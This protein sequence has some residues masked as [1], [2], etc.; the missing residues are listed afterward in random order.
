MG[1]APRHHD[2][3][4]RERDRPCEPP[5]RRPKRC[6]RRRKAGGLMGVVG[7][8]NPP[9]VECACPPFVPDLPEP[10]PVAPAFYEAVIPARDPATVQKELF[11]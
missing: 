6:K 1:A 3:H 4:A 10:E 7:T 8:Y 9:A 2:R 5:V 11:A